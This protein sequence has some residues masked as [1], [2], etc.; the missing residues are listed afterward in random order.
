ML[1]GEISPNETSKDVGMIGQ[2]LKALMSYTPFDDEHGG[3]HLTLL[4]EHLSSEVQAQTGEK[5]HILQDTKDIIWGQQ[6]EQRLAEIIQTINFLIPVITPSFFTSSNCRE[7]LL[8]FLQRERALARTDLI[9]PIYYIRT[10]LLESPDKWG[11]DPLAREIAKRTPVDWRELRF[12][13]IETP[14]VRKTLA[15]MAMQITQALPGQGLTPKDMKSDKLYLSAPNYYIVNVS[16]LI[17]TH[18]GQVDELLGQPLLIIPE[19]IGANEAIP[20]GGETREYALGRYHINIH[21]DKQGIARGLQIIEGLLEENYSLDKW[22][23]LLSRLGMSVIKEPDIKALAA[24]K[25][26]NYLGYAI[27]IFASK[28]NGPVWTVKVYKLPK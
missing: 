16:C 5:F 14:G 15:Q 27:D 10:P 4:R 9:L 18:I 6:F 1:F 2:E 19:G 25:W 13:P 21:F 3:G 12:E 22:P 28:P 24:R 20:D 7:E 26:K 8:Q 23:E 17:D 11:E